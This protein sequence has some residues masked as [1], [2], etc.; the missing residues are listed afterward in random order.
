MV[1]MVLKDFM[2]NELSNSKN[3]ILTIDINLQQACKK[4][5][6]KSINHYRA[7]FRFSFSNGY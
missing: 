2:T 7:E 1:K 3:I 5:L 4:K 6:M